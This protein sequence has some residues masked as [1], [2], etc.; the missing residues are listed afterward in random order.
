MFRLKSDKYFYAGDSIVITQLMGDSFRWAKKYKV[1]DRG[2]VVENSIRRGK[3]RFDTPSLPRVRVRWEDG[4][5]SMVSRCDLIHECDAEEWFKQSE[6]T[7]HEVNRWWM[8][9]DRWSNK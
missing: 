3:R 4:T 1:R 9:S 2:V 6:Q 8:E 5:E 7:W